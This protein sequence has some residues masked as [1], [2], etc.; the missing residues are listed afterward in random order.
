MFSDSGQHFRANLST[1]MKRPNKVWQLA[2]IVSELD[3]G[4][5][6][7]SRRRNGRPTDP[8]QR[9]K[10]QPCLGAAPGTHAVAA[11]ATLIE[12]GNFLDSST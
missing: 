2:G 4:P 3:V 12:S 11:R 5:S 7:T 1:I 8:C 6:M 9:P 10:H